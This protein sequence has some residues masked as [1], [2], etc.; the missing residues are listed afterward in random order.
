MERI[1]ELL[2]S[3]ISKIANSNPYNGDPTIKGMINRSN[4]VIENDQ[5]VKDIITE[6]SDKFIKENNLSESDL[7][8]LTTIRNDY[9]LKFMRS[10]SS[11]FND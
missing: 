4:Y 10:I 3:E 11:D 2:Q 1:K 7:E 9:Y 8:E 5:K 6:I